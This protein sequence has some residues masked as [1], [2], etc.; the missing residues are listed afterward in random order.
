MSAARPVS[1]RDTGKTPAECVGQA[2][3]AARQ[4]MAEDPAG[5]AGGRTIKTGDKTVT[6]CKRCF[7]YEK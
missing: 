6:A 5:A 4:A 2:V 7:S 1:A 3:A